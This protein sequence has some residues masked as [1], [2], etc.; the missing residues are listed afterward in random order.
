VVA[1]TATILR[2]PPFAVRVIREDDGAWLVL[3][4]AWLSR[5]D[6]VPIVDRSERRP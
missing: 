5:S 4:A 1:V 3:D 6:G 2:L